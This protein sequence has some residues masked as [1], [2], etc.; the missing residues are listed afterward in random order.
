MAVDS[1][2]LGHV[3][4]GLSLPAGQQIEPLEAGFLAPMMC[5]VYT[6]LEAVRILADD[7]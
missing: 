5:M 7:R 1:Q 4:A 3:Q 6:R 2:S